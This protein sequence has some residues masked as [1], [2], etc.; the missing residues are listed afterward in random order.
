MSINKTQTEM[1]TT[2]EW[3][4]A[5]PQPLHVLKTTREMRHK[6]KQEKKNLL[7][8]LA[9]QEI[10][11]PLSFRVMFPQSRNDKNRILNESKQ[12]LDVTI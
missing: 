11:K 1:K 2:E 6:R 4:F 7:G 3:I 9:L 12:G 8:F 10:S 5:I